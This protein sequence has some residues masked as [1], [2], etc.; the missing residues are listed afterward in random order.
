M[1]NTSTQVH[2]RVWICTNNH[3]NLF[4]ST[5]S[6]LYYCMD[7]IDATYQLCHV[8]M[9]IWPKQKYVN[10]LFF[11]ELFGPESTTYAFAAINFLTKNVKKYDLCW[12]RRL[13]TADYPNVAS[14]LHVYNLCIFVFLDKVS[15]MSNFSIIF[16]TLQVF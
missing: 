2:L 10:S 3:V 14:I 13:L 9:G 15:K 4:E 6:I 7:M 16:L 11:M 8:Q 5:Y 1:L 12:P